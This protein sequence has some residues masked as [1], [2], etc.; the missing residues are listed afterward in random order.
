MP[1]RNEHVHTEHLPL[2]IHGN[3][4][5]AMAEVT[6]FWRGRH[7]QNRHIKDHEKQQASQRSNKS[8]TKITEYSC[9]M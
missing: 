1:K 5:D 3:V 4:R 8:L 6:P 2:K 7:F 9:T